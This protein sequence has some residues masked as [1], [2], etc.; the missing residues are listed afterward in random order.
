MVIDCICRY[1]KAYIYGRFPMIIRIRTPA[2]LSETE[3]LNS[4]TGYRN[5]K[6]SRKLL[7]MPGFL[8]MCFSYVCYVPNVVQKMLNTIYKALK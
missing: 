7:Y 1:A 8:P 6:L 2:L 3:D 5:K 4:Y